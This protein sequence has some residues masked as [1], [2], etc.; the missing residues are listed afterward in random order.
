MLADGLSRA[1]TSRDGQ[2]VV[3]KFY[4]NRLKRQEKK[5]SVDKCLPIPE[6]SYGAET[7]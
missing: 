3:T 2:I 7:A 6:P 4:A 5:A 1:L